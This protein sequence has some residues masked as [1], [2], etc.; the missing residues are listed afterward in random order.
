MFELV[1]WTSPEPVAALLRRWQRRPVQRLTLLI[2]IRQARRVKAARTARMMAAS[3]M[4]HRRGCGLG[5]AKGEGMTGKAAKSDQASLNVVIRGAEKT[6]DNAER[7]F[8]EAEILAKDG[9]VARALCLHQISLEEC[10][11]VGTL[12]AW[13]VGLLV[14]FEVDQKE[15][16]AAVARHGAKNKSN[17][18]MLVPSEAEKD[19]R[20][21]G[22]SE[23][24]MA[25][26]KKTQDDFHET[27]NKAALYVDWIDG[28]FVAPSERITKE[29]LVEIAE[30]NAKFLGYAHTQLKMLSRLE[31]SPD[32]MRDLLFV[33]QAEWLRGEKPDDLTIAL[34][35]S[36]LV[37]QRLKPKG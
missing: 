27:S 31:A 23:A 1:R 16:L 24:W 34:F 4:R 14:G 29:M 18:Y 2:P 3:T 6:F 36:F 5:R 37:A 17:A 8:H 35:S 30:T 20:S 15:V 21:R 28:E 9:A 10:S 25:A 32:E 33:K 19:A 12:G 11:K 26:F 7:L 22:D 13:A